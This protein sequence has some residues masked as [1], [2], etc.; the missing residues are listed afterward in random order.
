[1][2]KLLLKVKVSYIVSLAELEPAIL[3]RGI[4]VPRFNE[5]VACLT[6]AA[7]ALYFIRAAVEEF[8]IPEFG[9]KSDWEYFKSVSSPVS[10]GDALGF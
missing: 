7:V 6:Y 9:G 3:F 8:D 4:S 5:Q 2:E 10:M 1:M